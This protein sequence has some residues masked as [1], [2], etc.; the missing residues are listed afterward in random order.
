MQPQFRRYTLQAVLV[1]VLAC[2]M[3]MP[4]QA[5]TGFVGGV[6]TDSRTGAPVQGALVQIGTSILGGFDSEQEATTG[7]DGRYRFE[8][9]ASASRVVFVVPPS[10]L[11]PTYWPTYPC[12][13]NPP[14]GLIPA[15]HFISVPSGQ[16]FV[17]DVVVSPPGAVAGR[18]L[19]D[20]N[21]Q[22]VEALTVVASWQRTPETPGFLQMQASTDTQGDYQFTGLPPGNYRVWV[23]GGSDLVSEVFDDIVC[24]G[25]CTATNEGITPVTVSAEQLTMGVD[26][27]LAQAA[28]LSGSLTDLAHPGTSPNI[29]LD[30]RRLTDT[31]PVV[32]G[33][34][35]S[36]DS[37]FTFSGLAAGTYVL[38]TYDCGGPCPTYVNEIYDDR[39]CAADQCSEAELLAGDQLVLAAG[40]TANISIALEPAASISGCITDAATGVGLPDVEA[41]VFEDA[42]FIGP[43]AIA[44]ATTGA[45]GCYRVEYL[46][47]QSDLRLMSLNGAGLVDEVYQDI[48]CLGSACD[49]L[50]GVEFALG[51]DQ[52]LSGFDMALAAGASLGGQVLLPPTDPA[53][54]EVELFLYD[55]MGRPARVFDMGIPV[56]AAAQFQ[57]YALADGVYYLGARYRGVSFLYGGEVTPGMGINPLEG[58]PITIAN[59]QSVEGLVFSLI[60][61]LIFADDF[62]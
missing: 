2:L 47:A 38:G 27:G 61:P 51:Y 7:S 60:S 8:V 24:D 15:G 17:A 62:E 53:P 42:L 52:D 3:C 40:E 34:L 43:R 49:A 5:Q 9:S 29:G 39:P 32:A 6:I 59:G 25:P 28:V 14:C 48:P 13:P 26:F 4:A 16:T 1:M 50:A 30:L 55:S 19:R 46:S 20:D 57:S 33:S 45:D 36:E 11:L 12:P 58:T 54:E 10:P 18:V 22:P 23:E 37:T 44:R 35:V 31:G 41:I 21:A 56:N